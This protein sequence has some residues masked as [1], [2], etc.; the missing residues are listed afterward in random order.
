MILASII[1]KNGKATYDDK[2]VLLTTIQFS[3]LKGKGEGG[4]VLMRK[5]YV[6]FKQENDGKN[7]KQDPT[8]SVSS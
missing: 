2:E 4:Y 6:K 7:N 8:C 3:I 1:L 5:E